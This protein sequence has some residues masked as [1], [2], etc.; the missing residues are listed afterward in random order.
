[1]LV[2]LTSL[3]PS[4][5]RFSSDVFSGQWHK[6]DRAFV[7]TLLLQRQSLVLTLWLCRIFVQFSDS[8]RL[9]LSILPLG[10]LECFCRL[11]P[12]ISFKRYHQTTLDIKISAPLECGQRCI[13]ATWLEPVPPTWLRGVIKCRLSRRKKIFC[14]RN[15]K[16]SLA[17]GLNLCPNTT[18]SETKCLKSSQTKL[19]FPTSSIYKRA[20][21]SLKFL[22]RMQSLW[23]HS[24]P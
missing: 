17:R 1:M 9:L 8:T 19:F 3:S 22:P 11:W 13:R 18:S 5:D 20:L 10:I 15:H 14:S 12:N 24:F 21:S 6:I 23:I 2:D 4:S 7:S 16:L